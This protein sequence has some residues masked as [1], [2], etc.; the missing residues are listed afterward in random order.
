[1]ARRTGTRPTQRT[2][3]VTRTSASRRRT[4]P[5]DSASGSGAQRG[6]TWRRAHAGAPAYGERGATERRRGPLGVRER[7]S[8]RNSRSAATCFRRRRQRSA[9]TAKVPSPS[10]APGVL[11]RVRARAPCRA[12]RARRT[13]A[14][15]RGGR[16]GD[17]PRRETPRAPRDRPRGGRQSDP[18]GS[19]NHVSNAA[20]PRSVTSYGARRGSDPGGLLAVRTRPSVTSAPTRDRSCRC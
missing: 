15:A 18:S 11:S 14:R 10:S 13:S 5:R 2:S 19:E 9:S 3:A 7:S 12:A 20:A 6:W 17:P 4:P 8:C 1:M 16:R